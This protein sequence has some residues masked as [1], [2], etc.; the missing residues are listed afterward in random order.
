VLHNHVTRGTVA[1]R[2]PSLN[3]RIH[4]NRMENSFGHGITFRGES[5]VGLVDIHRNE[6]WQARGNGIGF[7][8]GDFGPRGRPLPRAARAS[9]E[10]L[11]PGC[12][13]YLPSKGTHSSAMHASSRGDSRR[14]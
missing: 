10:P 5:Y 13:R 7:D 8:G 1:I 2:G 9:G 4:D 12:R 14:G 3:V 6:I 11:S